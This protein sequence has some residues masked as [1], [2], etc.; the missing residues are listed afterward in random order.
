MTDQ[1]WLTA[2]HAALDAAEWTVES[3][4]I[5][6]RF[7][8]ADASVHH[9]ATNTRKIILCPLDALEHPDTLKTEILR[10]LII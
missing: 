7:P 1:E 8:Y 4:G 3:A 5:M 6:P 10:Q 2:L 9:R